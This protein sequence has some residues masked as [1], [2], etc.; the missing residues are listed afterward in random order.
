[1]ASAGATIF[2]AARKENRF[3]LPNTRFLLHQPPGGMSGSASDVDIEVEQ[4]LGV[5]DRL[6]RMFARATGQD[7][8]RIARDTER[9]F[10]MSAEQARE[11]GLVHQILERL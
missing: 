11:Y 4:I 9:N 1:M 6:N 2:V 10:W 8:E 5:R 3:A 7:V